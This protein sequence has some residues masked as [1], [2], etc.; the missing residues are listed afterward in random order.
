M[1][2]PADPADPTR[3]WATIARETVLDRSPWLV[4]EKHSVRLPDGEVI[5]DWAWVVTPDYVIVA[6]IT[7][8]GSFLAFRQT[9]YAIT[10]ETLAAIGGYV[11]SGEEPLV[12][13]Q[14]ELREETGYE[15]PDWVEL[16][17]YVIDANRGVGSG[18]FYLAR[19]ARRVADAEADDLEDQ[20]LLLLNRAEIEESLSRGDFKVMAW[21][22][23]LALALLRIDLDDASRG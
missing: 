21:A 7:E 22:A 1:S 23:A 6:A 8:D 11:E 20:E 16:G 4:V 14:R 15:S 3:A 10:G 17:T 12:A 5:P 19:D 2:A 18:H 9:K 13:A